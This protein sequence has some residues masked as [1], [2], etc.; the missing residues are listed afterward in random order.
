MPQT[1]NDDRP[2]GLTR[3]DP[4]FEA[5]VDGGGFNALEPTGRPDAIVFP[6]TE[7]DLVEIV[8]AATET[9][10]KLAVRSGGHSWVASSVRPDGILVDL[11]AFDSVAIDAAARTATV[12]P[13]V[14]G[15]AL[16]A[17]L[18]AHDLAFPVGHCGNPGV[19]GYLLGGGLGLNWGQWL[20]ACFSITRLRAV[21][22]D[23]EIVTASPTENPDLFWLARG[24][25][26]GLPAIVT[27][28]ELVLQPLPHAIRVSTWLFALDALPAVT[29][30][31]TD[32]AA[33]LP[34]SVE[35]SVVTAGAGRPGDSE[36]TAAHPLVISV[37]ATA[38]ADTEDDAARALAPLGDGPALADPIAHAPFVPVPFERLH[39]PVDATYPD[40]ARYAT[41]TF[42]FDLDLDDALAPLPELVASAPSGQSYVLAGLPANGG[43]AALLPPGQAAYGLHD[44]SLLIVYTIWND[45]ADDAANL[46]W[47]AEV[48]QALL[49]R[50]TGH[51]VSEADIR[52]HPERVAGSFRPADWARVER[53]R[54]ELDAG[55]VFQGYP[56]GD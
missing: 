3:N 38:F 18:V 34:P 12:G 56:A 24:V 49:P 28:F 1:E 32:A 27:E 52:R 29:A 54:R 10:Q 48:Q 40:G 7:A 30:W 15:G 5:A 53:L 19:G 6:Q 42:W 14:R 35:L 13:A 46:G 26:P 47:L 39:E 23:G 55:G 51:F 33:H 43:G 9:G 37:A 4:G 45:A 25:G 16:A 31:L 41:D 20:P 21:T 44:R 11:S 17:R 2:A 50:A 36:D 8:R 22:A